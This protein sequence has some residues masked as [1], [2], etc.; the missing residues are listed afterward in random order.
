MG[1]DVLDAVKVHL[2]VTTGVET[3]TRNVTLASLPTDEVM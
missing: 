3:A 2:T 1:R